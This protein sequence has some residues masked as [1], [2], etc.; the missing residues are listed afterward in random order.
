VAGQP[1]VF[2]VA[3]V[4]KRFPGGAAPGT[5]DFVVTDRRALETALNAATPGSGF[6]TELWLETEPGG[7]A[8]VEARLRRA[9]FPLLAV[10]SQAALESSLRSDPVARAALAMLEASALI[11]I[12]LALLA[13]VLG[14]V[15]ERRDE[16]ADSF[17]LEA[18]GTP[19]ARLRRQLQL[20]AL[21]VAGAGVAGGILT[22]LVLSLLVVSFVELTANAT[23]PSPPLALSLDWLVVVASA[24]VAVALGAVLVGLVTG[25]AFRE[26]V[27]AR[28]GGT[29]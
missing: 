18:Q 23:A 3:A 14:V 5:D 15:S 6:P 11:A 20:R 2:R 17:D 10:S 12:L 8:A 16:A 21:V 22:G 27:P 13:L 25:R 1:L 26:P 28:Y 24:L 9:P 4:A 7:R 19:P 29:R